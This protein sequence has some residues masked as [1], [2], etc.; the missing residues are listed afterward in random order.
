MIVGA[1]SGRKTIEHDGVKE[2][3]SRFSSVFLSLTLALTLFLRVG[4][5]GWEDLVLHGEFSLPLVH[6]ER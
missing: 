2:G 1:R 5:L 4:R 6:W 3:L